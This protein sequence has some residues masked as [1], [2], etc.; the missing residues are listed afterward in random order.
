[1]PRYAESERQSLADLLVTLGPEAPT[2]NEGWGTRELAAH[3]VVRE[4]RPDAAVG[5][6][7]RPLAG[8]T[9]RMLRQAARRP[10]PELVDQV[11]HPPRWSPLS[12]AWLDE[13]A[14]GMEFF[15]HHEDVR[16]AQPDWRP[17]DL[18]PG[19]QA[20]LWRKLPLLTRMAL[21]RFPAALLVQAP[22][23]GETSTGAGGEPVRL[24]GSPGELALFLMGRQRV[25]RVQLTGSNTLTERLRTI[26]LGV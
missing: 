11:R 25:A 13:A 19:H 15:V 24:V 3:L 1:M 22:G 5:L 18:S 20:F 7:V 6:V 9:E 21:R 8:Y 12:N 4:R 23:Y 16:R 10:Y 14:N 17:R 26:R 2:I